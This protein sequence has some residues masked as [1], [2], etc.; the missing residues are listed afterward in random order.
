MPGNRLIRGFAAGIGIAT[1]SAG[2]MLGVAA[3][4]HQDLVAPRTRVGMVDVGGLTREEAAK[5]LRLWW[6]A[7]RRAVLSL[8][9]SRMPELP[10]MSAS[11]WGLR[12]DDRASVENLPLEPFVDSLQ[13][14]VGIEQQPPRIFEPVWVLDTESV[15]KLDAMVRRFAPPKRQARVFYRE[16]RLVRQAEIAGLELDR[17]RLLKNLLAAFQSKSPGQLPL[18]PA[19]QRVT[20][21]QLDQIAEVVSEYSTRFPARQHSRNN[22]IRLAAAK[23]DGTVLLPGESFSFNGVVGERKAADGYRIAGVFRNGRREEDIGGGI[24]Q[25]STTLYNT[26]LLANLKIV[27]RQNHSLPVAYVPS[28]RDAAVSYGSIDMRFQ[29]TLDHPIAISSQYETGKITFRIL[30][31][32]EPGLQVRIE[33]AGLKSWSRGVKY[34][35]DAS[36][37]PGKQKVIDKGGFGR[38][39]STYRVVLKDGKVE[40]REPLGQSVYRGAPKLIA[41]NRKAAHATPVAGAEASP[42]EPAPV[43]EQ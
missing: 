13:R 8:A 32:K 20:D 37:P 21:E 1:L 40:R 19:G 17:D 36:L 12:L 23:I 35:D 5:K 28:G 39:V 43:E 38:S 11:Q 15:A 42:A 31:R 33:S 16:G 6:D 7:E 30:G 4:R 14:Q 34:V 3:A 2:T 29:N 25:V 9:D 24:C 10:P 22:N 26:A 41:I 18:A 27:Q